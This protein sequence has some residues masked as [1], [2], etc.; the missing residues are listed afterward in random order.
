[1]LAI[2]KKLPQK[3]LWMENVPIPSIADDEVLIKTKEAS[4]CGTDLH[5]YNW[6]TWAQKTLHPPLVIGHEFMGE[7]AKIGKNVKGLNVGDRVSG[8]GHIT[9]GTCPSCLTEKR[10]LCMHTQGLG[11]H[12]HGC[13]AEYFNLPAANVFLL[14]T[15]IPDD[16]GAIMDPFGNAVHTALTFPLAGED[17]VITGA[18]PIGIMS[19]AVARKAGARRVVITDKNPYRL[20]LAKQMGATHTVDITRQSLR[21]VMRE[22]DIEWGFSVGFEM[23][24]HPK[25]LQELI[26]HS[27]NGANIALLGILP[28]DCVI[29]WDLVIFKMLTIKGIY[30]REIFKTWFQME[31]LLEAGLDLRPIITHRFPF[32]DFEQAFAAAQ[33]GN[34]G[35]LILH[36]DH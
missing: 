16:I 28:P 30:G 11:I 25:A 2:T 8:E 23:S 29:D 14:P 13:F 9:C 1:M 32:H 20:A 19:A 33:S 24:G 4:I 26:E 17:V 34:A 15:S 36:W 27:Q 31:H 12:R 6:D 7:I 3:G 35:K 22:A 5:I 18:G 21:D 10:H